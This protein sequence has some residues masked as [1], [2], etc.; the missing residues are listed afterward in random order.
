MSRQFQI[1]RSVGGEV[2]GSKAKTWFFV[3]PNGSINGSKGVVVQ[4]FHGAAIS[5]E[6][7]VIRQCSSEAEMGEGNDVYGCM[8]LGR[9]S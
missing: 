1:I 4:L 9:G 6:G 8:L 5:W 3:M 7:R 2:T